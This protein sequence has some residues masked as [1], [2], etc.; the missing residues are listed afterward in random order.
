[1]CVCVRARVRVRMP[2]AWCVCVCVCVCVNSNC[3][4]TTPE[5]IEGKAMEV[6]PRLSAFS[7]QL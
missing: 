4:L 2:Y 1:M 6:N 5:L 3:V 7:R